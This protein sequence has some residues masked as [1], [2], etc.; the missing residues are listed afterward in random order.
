MAF[1]CFKSLWKKYFL[2]I[3]HAKGSKIAKILNFYDYQRRLT[4]M[5][6][7]VFDTKYKDLYTSKNGVIKGKSKLNLQLTK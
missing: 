2:N 1:E 6:Y 7:K 4:S 3:L 5:V